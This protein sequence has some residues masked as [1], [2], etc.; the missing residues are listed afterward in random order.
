[1]D[2]SKMRGKIEEYI[3]SWEQWI[4]PREN[5]RVG[6][7]PQVYIKLIVQIE[8]GRRKTQNGNLGRTT[9]LLCQEMPPKIFGKHT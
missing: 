7:S 6:E 1:M 4:Q 8:A 5:L 2:S 3:K 9:R